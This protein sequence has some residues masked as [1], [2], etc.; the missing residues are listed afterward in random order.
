MRDFTDFIIEQG[1]VDILLV[2][3]KFTWSNAGEELI[4]FYSLLTG[5]DIFL[6]Q[7]RA[8]PLGS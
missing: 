5:K 4:N 7:F 8:L 1:L 2:G 6:M 3:G